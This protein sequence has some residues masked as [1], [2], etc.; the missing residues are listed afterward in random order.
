[1]AYQILSAKRARKDL[2][3]LDPDVRQRII[4]GIERF[5]EHGHGDVKH[6]TD[7]T[8]EYR[9]RI[10]DYR[11]LFEREGDTITV[12]RIKHRRDAYS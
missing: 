4:S 12:Y 10:G 9:L 8:P 2:R 11:V 7:F 3:K 6:L 1:M 5:A